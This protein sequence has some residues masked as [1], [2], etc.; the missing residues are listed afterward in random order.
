M[1]R[2]QKVGLISAMGS[3][4]QIIKELV[5]EIRRQ[6]GTEDDVR[7]L[8]TGSQPERPNELIVKIATM[9]VGKTK[10]VW[11]GKIKID[12]SQTLDQRLELGR[13]GLVMS[14]IPKLYPL[15][16]RQQV[17]DPEVVLVQFNRIKTPDEMR[18]EIDSLG[19]KLADIEDLI[20]F[21]TANR[22]WVCKLNGILALGGVKT[23]EE[24]DA[25]LEPPSIF[26]SGMSTLGLSSHQFFCGPGRGTTIICRVK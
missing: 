25:Y 12:H 23:T 1:P 7:Q 15:D 9:L 16:I 4:F 19:F 14:Q 20:A 17:E 6:E 21:G 22:E 10:I 5:E 24:A 8:L 26:W 2:K 11:R 13:Y 18:K 3:G